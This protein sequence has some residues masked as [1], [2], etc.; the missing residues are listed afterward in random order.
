[1]K[2]KKLTLSNFMAFENLQLV[3]RII[4]MLSA[5]RTVP[6]RQHY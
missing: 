4:L 2:I 1:M 6:E 3:G 5:E